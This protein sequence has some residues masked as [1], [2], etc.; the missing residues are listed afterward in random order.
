MTDVSL[1]AV[2]EIALPLFL[3][4]DPIG[5][6]AMCLPMLSKYTP[7]QQRRILLRELLIALGIIFLFH[8]LGE[9]LLGVLNIHQSTLRLSGGFILFLI[10]I[11]MVFPTTGEGLVDPD[12]EPFI[13]PIAIPFIAGPSLLAAVMLYA[14]RAQTTHPGMVGS[15]SVLLGIV[16]AWAATVIIMMSAPG[17]MRY[18]GNRGMR[19]AER[20]MGLILVF[21]AVQML[22]DGIKMFLTSLD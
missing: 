21:L 13:V 2:F 11:K 16:A 6:A 19:A 18:L 7:H 5:N 1:R 10:A 4:M 22:E 14:H 8:Y 9:W 15:P 17:L 3:I 12:Q 20:L